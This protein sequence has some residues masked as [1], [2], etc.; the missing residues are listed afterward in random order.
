MKKGGDKLAESGWD[1][2][3][4]VVNDLLIPRLRGPASSANI[5][6]TSKKRG[7]LYQEEVARGTHTVEHYMKH[8]D[9][10]LH[11]AKIAMPM[12]K[13]TEAERLNH[14]LQCI[15][16]KLY[17]KGGVADTS[18]KKS[19]GEQGVLA[20]VMSTDGEVYM[21]EY[22]QHYS[23]RSKSISHGS[24]LDGMPVIMAGLIA[25][26]GGKVIKISNNSGHYQPD[27]LDMYRGVRML[28]GK[29]VLADNCIIEIREKE[30][31]L[32]DF[33]SYMEWDGYGKP[34]WEV[35]KSEKQGDIDEKIR[36]Y[37]DPLFKAITEGDIASID[38]FI[39]E[40]NKFT[41]K[42]A[43]IL[44]RYAASIGKPSV[45]QRLLKEDIDVNAFDHKRRNAVYVAASRK[46]E[47]TVD[48]LLKAGG[49]P[50]M[51]N[52][53]GY[54]TNDLAPELFAVDRVKDLIT[55]SVLAKDEK[56]VN[57]LAET[58]DKLVDERFLSSAREDVKKKTGE[59]HLSPLTKM[60]LR[61][62]AKL[63]EGSNILVSSDDSALGGN[64]ENHA[65]K[66]LRKRVGVSIPR[67]M[68]TTF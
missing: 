55:K 41:E 5:K 23:L 9:G 27:E 1:K 44:L 56:E 31:S 28:E 64:K 53:K 39:E 11:K 14:Q 43:G 32:N 25:I 21:A 45:V 36:L 52:R 33:K 47:A 35:L 65:A 29:K 8:D 24:F 34:Y 49:D 3:R 19:K 2:V 16:G 17:F 51:K 66:E 26:S 61:D 38:K 50:Y 12:I 58:F 57:N 18:G 30:Q 63:K 13:M 7:D 37:K 62:R 59:K 67:G 46:D 42:R 54:S 15:D 10:S 22:T 6:F 4:R 48:L 40:G 60:V 20:F 68:K